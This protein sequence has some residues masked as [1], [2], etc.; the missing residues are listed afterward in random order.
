MDPP[1]KPGMTTMGM[2]GSS[3]ASRNSP[4]TNGR[5]TSPW[6]T[7]GMNREWLPCK[8]CTTSTS[9]RRHR[10]RQ[11]QGWAER[12]LMRPTK[13]G[14][15]QGDKANRGV[16]DKGPGFGPAVT[17]SAPSPT[18]AD[19]S[20]EDPA[21]P[22]GAISSYLRQNRVLRRQPPYSVRREG[23]HARGSGSDAAMWPGPRSPSSTTCRRCRWA[24]R[25][26]SVYAGEA[27]T[28]ARC[29]GWARTM[30]SPHPR[31][32]EVLDRGSTWCSASTTRASARSAS[33]PAG[34]NCAMCGGDVP[35]AGSNINLPMR[36]ASPRP[37]RRCRRPG[38]GA[39]VTPREQPISAL[40]NATRP[41]QGQPRP[42][43]RGLRPAMASC[44]AVSGRPRR[45]DLWAER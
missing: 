30:R 23:D 6:Q 1:D 45:P 37:G 15:R 13:Q 3:T 36:H 38:A 8:N 7:G 5:L 31:G 20:R 12:R 11:A 28:G 14:R 39:Q 19:A 9:P 10:P 21:L 22:A 17:L 32:A 33:R 41:T 34:S 42:A 29:P 43:E 24:S 2:I 16:D 44:Q 4:E 25:L 18:S 40:A 27:E 26:P 35:G